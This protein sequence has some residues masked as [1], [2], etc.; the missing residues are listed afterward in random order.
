MAAVMLGTRDIPAVTSEVGPARHWLSELLERDHAAIVDD[1]VLLAC[2]LVTNA[3]RHT[4]STVIPLLVLDVG[5]AVR[6]EVTDAGSAGVPH[7]VQ[8]DPESLNGRGLHLIDA[9]SK[10]RWGSHAD[11]AGRTVWFEI[12]LST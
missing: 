9:I 3:I 5:D 12:S 11:E 2:E 6:V 10:G 4:E 8:D 7:L 1:V